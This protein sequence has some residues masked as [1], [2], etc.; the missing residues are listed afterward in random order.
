MPQNTGHGGA[1][2]EWPGSARR[3]A[4]CSAP[5]RGTTRCWRTS[6]RPLVGVSVSLPL[7]HVAL[8]QAHIRRPGPSPTALIPHRIHS[9]NARHAARARA[10][11]TEP[12]PTY[13]TRPAQPHFISRSLRGRGGTGRHGGPGRRPVRMLPLAIPL[14]SFLTPRRRVHRCTRGL[15]RQRQRRVDRCCRAATLPSL[16]DGPRRS[17]TSRPGP[18]PGS[19]ELPDA[20][21]RHLL[22]VRGVSP[23][24]PTTPPSVAPPPPC[25]VAARRRGWQP[26]GAA[27]DECSAASTHAPSARPPPPCR[28]PPTA[29]SMQHPRP[30]RFLRNRGP[31]RR[32]GAPGTRQLL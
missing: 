28:P 8:R 7:A 19:V 9:A 23:P 24:V 15:P 17:Q 20:D 14:A 13:G 18:L 29:S 4:A 26:G 31:V 25:M 32:G 12:G 5:G 1:H 6:P 27:R 10:G 22:S 30:P 21:P 3:G 11:P 16:D 2:T